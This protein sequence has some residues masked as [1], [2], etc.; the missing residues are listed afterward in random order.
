MK[1]IRY[2]IIDMRTQAIVATVKTRANATRTCDRRDAAY[3]AVR[4]VARP[5][6]EA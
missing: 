5:V 6:W 2:D 3:G 1:P 4:Y